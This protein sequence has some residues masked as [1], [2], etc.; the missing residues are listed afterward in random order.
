MIKLPDK[1]LFR[2]DEVA[3]ILG[4]KSLKTID[5]WIRRGK[6]RYIRTPGGQRRIPRKELERIAVELQEETREQR[7]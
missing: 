5:N 1:Q 6:I 3:N 4:I 7:A 2:P